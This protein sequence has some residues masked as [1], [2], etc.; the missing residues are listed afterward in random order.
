MSEITTVLGKLTDTA[1]YV[2]QPGFNV[3]PKF[4][5][6]TPEKGR[7]WLREAVARGDKFLLVSTDFTGA[8]LQE[9]RWLQD[10]VQKL[11]IQARV[12]RERAWE[13]SDAI[14]A[15]SKRAIAHLGPVR[16]LEDEVKE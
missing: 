9:I 6:W 12:L 11:G 14:A 5:D 8:Y 2:G 7:A 3:Y 10:E 15:V 1:P 4:D 16:P 13:L